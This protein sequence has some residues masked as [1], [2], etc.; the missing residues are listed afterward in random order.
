MFNLILPKEGSF[1]FDSDY[2]FFFTR[3]TVFFLW[4]LIFRC[5]EFSYLFELSFY[6]ISKLNI[7]Q[8]S[9]FSFL[10]FSFTNLYFR[11]HASYR[12]NPPL[13]LSISSFLLSLPIRSSLHSLYFLPLFLFFFSFLRCFSRLENWIFTS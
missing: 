4:N 10:L 12:V 11:E 1:I 2:L 5:M 9:F 3:D 6:C 7:P 8:L 13:S